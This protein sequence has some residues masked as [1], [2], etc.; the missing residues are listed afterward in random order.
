[1]VITLG[2]ASVTLCCPFS[3]FMVGQTA[4]VTASVGQVGT[5]VLPTGTVAFWDNGTSLGS[6]I[7][8]ASGVGTSANVSFPLATVGNHNITATYSGDANYSSSSAPGAMVDYAY[9]PTTTTISANTVNPAAGAS[10][11]LTVL[12]DTSQSSYTPTGTPI[13]NAGYGAALT[14]T[15]GPITVTQTKDTSGYTELQATANYTPHYNTETV[16]AAYPGDVN[17]SYSSTAAQ[18]VNIKVAGSDYLFYGG[19]TLSMAAGQQGVVDFTV[20]GQLSYAGT[21]NFTASSCSG[22]PALSNCS[23]TPTS[24]TG[25]GSV[26]VLVATTGPSSV[27]EHKARAFSSTWWTSTSMLLVGGLFLLMNPSRRRQSTL[28]GL[29]I[30]ALIVT[31]PSCSSGGGGGGN[32]GTPA[33]TYTVTVTAASGSLSHSA[34]FT[35][36]IQ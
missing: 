32:G 33:G 26:S 25:S 11:A 17:F 34:N 14:G 15:L 36:V 4:S 7:I 21:I 12:V 28:L 30:L 22:L 3:N 8:S 24:L 5:G 27:A 16:Y 1:M 31:L 35:L 19:G 10:V 20:D 18:P 9:Y 29:L 13:I 2:A 6:A 23:F